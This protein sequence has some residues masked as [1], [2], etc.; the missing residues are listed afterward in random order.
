MQRD[1]TYSSVAL[2]VVC[3]SHRSGCLAA[4]PKVCNAAVALFAIDGQANEREG[5]CSSATAAVLRVSPYLRNMKK[6]GMHS[7]G[8]RLCLWHSGALRGLV[9]LLLALMVVSSERSCCYSFPIQQ[10]FVAPAARPPGLGPARDH[11]QGLPRQRR[12]TAGTPPAGRK[13]KR[14]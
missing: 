3:G 10:A 7:G 6:A 8:C 9:L 13:V 11:Q 1:H 4:R 14:R 12:R 5:A 2:G